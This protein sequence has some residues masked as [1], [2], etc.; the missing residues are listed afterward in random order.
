MAA[1]S[2]FSPSPSTNSRSST[3]LVRLV[4]ITIHIGA[5]AFWVPSNQPSS[6]KLSKAA[7]ALQARM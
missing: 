3:I 5:R 1:P 2:T 6:T 7:G 4:M